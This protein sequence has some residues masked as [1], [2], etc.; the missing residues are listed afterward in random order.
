M[1]DDSAS[2]FSTAE[3]LRRSL[4][5]LRGMRGGGT[6]LVTL[7]VPPDRLVSDEVGL[8]RTEGAQAANIKDRG[9]RNAVGSAIG[10][11]L[12]AVARFSFI[13]EHGLAVFADDIG[14]SVIIPPVA[15]KSH[16]YRCAS[17]YVLEPLEA[18]LQSRQVYGLVVMDRQEL[19]VGLLRGK[20]T[21]TLESVDSGVR[22]KHHMGGQSQARYA[23]IIQGEFEAFIVRAG[24]L[25]NRAFLPLL[26]QLSG[27]LVGG[28]GMTKDLLLPNLDYRLRP[29]V[30]SPTLNVGYTDEN[31]L[32]ELVAQAP[33]AVRGLEVDAER[34]LLGRFFDGLRDGKAVYGAGAVAEAWSEGRV[35][36]L[37]VAEK[38]PLAGFR[39]QAV[40]VGDETEEGRRFA[41]LGGIGAI[42]RWAP[43]SH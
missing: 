29:L 39:S 26:G 8:L 41:I 6:T 21:L 34:R 9:T 1:T 18:M 13:P 25:C 10:H 24:E 7:Y 36:A 31:G 15:L 12:H 4:L 16:L 14:A 28:P 27:I 33:Q 38:G 17:A 43:S 11:A 23:R 19:T 30:V 37:L 32:R 20:A 3:D 2:V 40:R 5:G 22:G 35:E 42:L